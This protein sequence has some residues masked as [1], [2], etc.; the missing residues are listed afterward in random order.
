MKKRLIIIA[1]VLIIIIP[2]SLMFLRKTTPPPQ[3]SQSTQKSNS[4]LVPPPLSPL[5]E[6]TLGFSQSS[7]TSTP[8]QS[9]KL[10]IQI[11]T[12]NN[13][14]TAVQMAI[15]YDPTVFSDVTITPGTFFPNPLEFQNT[16]DPI[17]GKILFAF[18]PQPTDQA[19]SGTGEIAILGFTISP[20]A[21]QQESTI[22]FLPATI[23][24]A[25][26][27]P[28]SVLKKTSNVIFTIAK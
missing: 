15:S 18:A 19:K 27:I 1:I 20:T 16:V 26:K 25:E 5:A 21:K 8:G 13:H 11:T 2:L 23:V 12:G 22:T 24:T 9:S 4:L 10:P 3:N 17:S 7:I 28:E 6:T 14:I